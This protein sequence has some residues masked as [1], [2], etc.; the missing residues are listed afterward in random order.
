[1]I[2][3]RLLTEVEVPPPR[4][5]AAANAW[6]VPGDRDNVAHEPAPADFN[7]KVIRPRVELER[8]VCDGGLKAPMAAIHKYV[9]PRSGKINGI[10]RPAR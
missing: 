2:L 1:M 10:V 7:G 8:C 4:I 9:R 3:C 6:R 5:R